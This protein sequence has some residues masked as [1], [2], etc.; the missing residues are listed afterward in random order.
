VEDSIVEPRGLRNDRRLMV[1]Y[2]TGRF[3]TQRDKPSLA[4][5]EP[6]IQDDKLS[7]QA[8]GMET[9]SI[10]LNRHGKERSVDVWNDTSKAADQG[11]EVAD[12]FSTFLRTRCRLVQIGDSFQRKAKVS[13]DLTT[14]VSFADHY[15]LVITTQ[16]SL[17][18][19]NDRLA[20]PLF[21]SQ[22]RP[23]VVLAGGT[24]FE[25]YEWST[26]NIGQT[27]LIKVEDCE[28]CALT[29]INQENGTQGKEPLH[30]LSS[31]RL[32]PAHRAVFG[33]HVAAASYGKI[34]LR[35]AVTAL[36]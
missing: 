19:L 14:D 5:V 10:T 18:Y 27:E 35:S 28:R 17:D 8:P 34:S 31:M 4:L 29:L 23:N 15:P 13:R 25:E 21:M 1:V 16:E 9:I 11:D 7:L 33:I 30:I 24:A 6:D 3:L 22:M 12:W 20:E 26:I 2:A 36:K 32:K